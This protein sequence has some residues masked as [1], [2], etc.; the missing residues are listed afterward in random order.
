[1]GLQNKIP[2]HQ[3][4]WVGKDFDMWLYDYPA[5]DMTLDGWVDVTPKQENQVFM[6]WNSECTLQGEFEEL[7]D[8]L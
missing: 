6:R 8:G 1:M 7:D 2:F 3:G 5:E 4:T